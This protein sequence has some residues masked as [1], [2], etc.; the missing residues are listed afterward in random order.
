MINRWERE[1]SVD[2]VRWHWSGTKVLRLP[3]PIRLLFCDADI[4]LGGGIF[5]LMEWIFPSLDTV[6][7]SLW[8]CVYVSVCVRVYFVD[9]SLHLLIGCWEPPGAPQDRTFLIVNDSSIASR[10][11]STCL[12]TS[13]PTKATQRPDTHTGTQKKKLN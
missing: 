11:T 5:N 12:L 10:G 4:K 6:Q 8:W 1:Q 2:A 3:A 7:K 13:T 9:F